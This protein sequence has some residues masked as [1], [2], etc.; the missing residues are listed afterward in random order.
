MFLSNGIF[1]SQSRGRL[2]IQDV[3]QVFNKAALLYLDVFCFEVLVI[4]VVIV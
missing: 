3:L 2:K 1:C 4:I